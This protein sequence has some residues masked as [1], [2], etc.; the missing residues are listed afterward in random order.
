MSI[1]IQIIVG[2]CIALATVCL[3]MIFHR[4]QRAVWASV[5]VLLG[6]VTVLG[7]IGVSEDRGKNR[8]GK[9]ASVENMS[10]AYIGLAYGFMEEGA[11]ED[12]EIFLESYLSS[13]VYDDRY[14]LARARLYGLQGN[15]D[16]A[17]GL[18]RMLLDKK[19]EAAGKKE[20]EEE[21]V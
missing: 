2:M 3:L 17:E 8:K 9:E 21:L 18:Y 6:I 5:F 15:Y 11:Y 20:L 7:G 10:D 13:G 16:G 14:L 1:G 12:A 19:S 4:K